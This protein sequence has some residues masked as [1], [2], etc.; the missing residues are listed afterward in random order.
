MARKKSEI[1]AKAHIGR[2]FLSK[3]EIQV[4]ARKVSDHIKELEEKKENKK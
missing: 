2:P 4:T 3:E 1:T